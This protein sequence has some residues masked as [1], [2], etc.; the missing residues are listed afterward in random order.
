MLA[1]RLLE[2]KYEFVS[3]S[4]T[5]FGLLNN[6]NMTLKTYCIDPPFLSY[7]AS[8][9]P[10]LYPSI[11]SSLISSHNLGHHFSAFSHTGDVYEQVNF[12]HC[13]ATMATPS[14]A[15]P[16]MASPPTASPSPPSTAAK[17][18][19]VEIDLDLIAERLRRVEDRIF[20]IARQFLYDLQIFDDHLAVAYVLWPIVRKASDLCLAARRLAKTAA[21]I[22]KVDSALK[23]KKKK[24]KTTIASITHAVPA[25]PAAPVA[26]HTPETFSFVPHLPPE[27]QDMIWT[28][29]AQPRLVRITLLISI[30][31]EV[32]VE[33]PQRKL[34]TTGAFGRRAVG[35]AALSNGLMRKR[36]PT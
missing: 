16:P 3:A 11:F 25:V 9:R 17:L 34:W 31:R 5:E 6:A 29:A 21:L 7:T 13:L 12:T 15:S 20:Q 8:S 23:N 2:A 10:I 26:P 27:L 28:A 36:A 4:P 14:A 35:P 32:V 33:S 18:G 24:R 19:Q 30:A 1:C 22:T